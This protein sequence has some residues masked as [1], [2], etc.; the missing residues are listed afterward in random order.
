VVAMG[1]YNFDMG[2]VLFVGLAALQG[3]QKIW[4]HIL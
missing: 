4:L 2:V 3:S 1:D